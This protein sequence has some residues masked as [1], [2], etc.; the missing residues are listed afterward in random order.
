MPPELLTSWGG[1]RRP[2]TDLLHQPQ[3]IGNDCGSIGGLRI[4]RGNPSTR[5][6]PAPVPFCPP[7]DLT[8]ARTRP[9][10]VKTRR[11]T[12]LVM[13]QPEL[14]TT[15]LTLSS[16]AAFVCTTYYNTPV[17]W[18]SPR[19]VCVFCTTPATSSIN[20]LGFVMEAHTPRH[21]CQI[22]KGSCNRTTWRAA[23]GA[24]YFTVMLAI[25][26]PFF[27]PVFFWCVSFFPSS[28]MHSIFCY[29]L[30]Y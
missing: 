11:Q 19:F 13:T 25:L 21:N 23:T 29:Q 4:D 12:I 24:V 8:W 9:A 22:K 10:A 2:L 26:F 14:L 6:Q 28:M 18:F 3:M 17:L 30:I 15:L 7:H 16:T 27:E 5:R 1:V 20:L